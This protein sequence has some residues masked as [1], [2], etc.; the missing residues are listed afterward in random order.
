MSQESSRNTAGEEPT[1]SSFPACCHEMAG[2][3]EDCGPAMERM[4]SACGPMIERMRAAC[5]EKSQPPGPVSGDTDPAD[6]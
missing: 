6:A 5:G 4:M 1:Q 3:M 2:G